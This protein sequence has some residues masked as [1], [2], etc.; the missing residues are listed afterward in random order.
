MNEK[1]PFSPI[2]FLREKIR[3][4]Q[5]LGRERN[6]NRPN[7]S[8]NY[9]VRRLFFSPSFPSPG[10]NVTLSFFLMAFLSNTSRGIDAA[11]VR[12]WGKEASK[13]SNPIMFCPPRAFFQRGAKCMVERGEEMSRIVWK[14]GLKQLC[15]YKVFKLPLAILRSY[16][17]LSIKADYSS[18]L[19][20]HR[21][22]IYSTVSSV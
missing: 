10:A 9:D 13:L 1:K 2:F 6:R 4:T 20:N 22:L 18:S 17:L 3:R 11:A 16:S 8:I 7:C 12:D 19:I 14:R 21:L 15:L 5:Q